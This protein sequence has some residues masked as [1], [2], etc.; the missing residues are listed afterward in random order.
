MFRI[1]VNAAPH[2]CVLMVTETSD[3]DLILFSFIGSFSKFPWPC[4]SGEQA[5]APPT[6]WDLLSVKELFNAEILK[7]KSTKL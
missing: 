2:L 6:L 1:M 7:M 3:S 4:T 5:G